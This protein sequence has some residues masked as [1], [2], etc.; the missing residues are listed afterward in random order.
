MCLSFLLTFAQMSP[1]NKSAAEDL[2]P[3]Q[4]NRGITTI[5]HLSPRSAAII[6]DSDDCENEMPELISDCGENDMPDLIPTGTSYYSSPRTW[7]RERDSIIVDR[8]LP[9]VMLVILDGMDQ[10]HRPVPYLIHR[11]NN[12]NQNTQQQA[13]PRN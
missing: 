5:S 1:T 13:P 12:N 4:S 10:Y 9:P 2:N 11:I 8:L 3:P 6:D 7:D